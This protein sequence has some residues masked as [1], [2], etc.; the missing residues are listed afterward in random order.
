MLPIKEQAQSFIDLTSAFEK[1]IVSAAVVGLA[2]AIHAF[3]SPA[4]EDPAARNDLR[5]AENAKCLAAGMKP[6]EKNGW[7]VCVPARQHETM[8]DVVGR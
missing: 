5:V 3:I 1:V 6:T 2:W 8:K 4:F 7:V